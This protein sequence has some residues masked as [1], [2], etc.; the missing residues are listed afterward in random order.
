MGLKVAIIP[1]VTGCRTKTVRF[2]CQSV[3]FLPHTSSPVTLEYFAKV[4]FAAFSDV[5]ATTL[6]ML[7]PMYPQQKGELRSNRNFLHR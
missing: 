3:S 5:S 1:F 4:A 7:F 6:L 2:E